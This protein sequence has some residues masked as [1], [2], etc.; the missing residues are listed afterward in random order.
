MEKWPIFEQNHGL[1]PLEKCQFFDFYNLLFLL[2]RKRFFLLE[3]DK[4]RFPSLYCLKKIS[5]KNYQF[6]SKTMG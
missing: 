2:A 4:T 3:Y 5:W 1:T 6:S